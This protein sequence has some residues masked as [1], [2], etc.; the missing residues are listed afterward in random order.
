M[1]W[2]DE[3]F[4]AL[5]E[6][7]QRRKERN[8]RYSVRQ[9]AKRVGVS[10]GAMS[11]ILRGKRQLTPG[12]SLELLK[13]LDLPKEETLR[14]HLLLGGTASGASVPVGPLGDL[15]TDWRRLHRQALGDVPPAH[16]TNPA[17]NFQLN[18]ALLNLAS[19]NPPGHE[20]L[21]FRQNQLELMQNISR[22]IDPALFQFY[23]LFLSLSKEQAREALESLRALL[24]RWAAM[25]PTDPS[26]EVY[27]FSIQAF[28]VRPQGTAKS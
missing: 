7:F 25:R 8:P 21:A 17:S 24:Y 5:Q 1:T 16:E 20:T 23:S 22:E 28:P 14:L 11:E 10:V 27:Q 19:T 15:A 9:Y 4:R 26:Y 2:Q 12:R 3:F 18:L 6:D 13:K